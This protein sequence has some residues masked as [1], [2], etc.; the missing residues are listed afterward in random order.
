MAAVNSICRPGHNESWFPNTH[1]GTQ[2]A[3]A[4]AQRLLG[5]SHVA[6]VSYPAGMQK[7]K[8]LGELRPLGPLLGKTRAQARLWIKENKVMNPRSAWRQLEIVR[9][10]REDGVA[11]NVTCDSRL[12]RVNV[13]LENGVVSRIVD[14]G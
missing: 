10:V 14:V 6:G 3:I 7:R 4:F 9:V 11:N 2:A 1:E 13:E 5:S 12:E 8:T